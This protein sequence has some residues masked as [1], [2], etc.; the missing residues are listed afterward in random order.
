MT[1]PC[2]DKL[3][4][5]TWKEAIWRNRLQ[6][7]AQS[8]KTIAAFYHDES[9][10][11]TSFQIWRVKLAA[12]SGHA[13]N[14]AQPTA[15]IDLGAIKDVAGALALADGPALAPTSAGGIDVRI[16]LGGGG[17]LTITRRKCSSLKARCASS[18]LGSR[19]PCACPL[20]NSTRWQNTSCTRIAVRTPVRAHQPPSDSDPR[21]VLRQQRPVR[22]G[23][24]L[25]QGRFVSNWAN[26]ARREMNWKG[27]K[28][29]LEGIEP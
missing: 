26:V 7:Q 10:S 5:H 14:L 3:E 13:A 4:S 24:R 9:V 15:F 16:D 1:K 12:A 27:L 25:E 19:L 17:A 20:T 22:V 6:L 2:M 8:G 18:W 11:T 23:K 21:P 28:L 29:L